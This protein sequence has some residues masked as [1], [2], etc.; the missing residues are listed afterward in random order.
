M[1]SKIEGWL[2]HAGDV[3]DPNTH[4]KGWGVELT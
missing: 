3:I 4:Q 1:G 2:I